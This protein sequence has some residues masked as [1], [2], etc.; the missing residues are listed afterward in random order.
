[1]KIFIFIVAIL[2][3]N[4]C[5]YSQVKFFGGDATW[6]MKA[7]GTDF[8]LRTTDTARFVYNPTLKSAV[9]Y[10]Y[11]HKAQHPTLTLTPKD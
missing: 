1:M 5:A 8:G 11:T 2:L 3:L 9:L 7:K 6:N 10:I 4:I